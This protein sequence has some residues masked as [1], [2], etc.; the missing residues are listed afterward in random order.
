MYIYNIIPSSDLK[1][2]DSCTCT[3]ST[4]HFMLHYIYTCIFSCSRSMKESVEI[5][6]PNVASIKIGK[7]H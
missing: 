2:N 5:T 6:A 4:S 7:K 1:L 3:L